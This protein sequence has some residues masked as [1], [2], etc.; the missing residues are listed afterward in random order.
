LQL[1][2]QQ[3]KRNCLGVSS[4]DTC[5]NLIGGPFVSGWAGGHYQCTI[6]AGSGCTGTRAMVDR[7]GWSKFDF[8]AWSMRC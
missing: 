3:G 1:C 7:E 4:D 2:K 6:Y 5:I 8:N